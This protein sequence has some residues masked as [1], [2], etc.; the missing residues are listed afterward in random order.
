M[1]EKFLAGAGLTAAVAASTC[2]VLPVGLGVIGVS[3]AWFASLAVFAPYQTFF[4]LA[5]IL[6]LGATFWLVYGRSRTGSAG[7]ECGQAPSRT[8]TK[9]VLWLGILITGL[10]LSAGWW[11]QF[12]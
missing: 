3:S 1:L 9:A 11:Q 8:I 6:L 5:A 10:V 4:R 7:V 12:V 2:C